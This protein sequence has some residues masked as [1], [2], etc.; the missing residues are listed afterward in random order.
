MFARSTVPHASLTQLIKPQC[1]DLLIHIAKH[2]STDKE[3]PSLNV[4]RTVGILLK[5]VCMSKFCAALRTND[6][7]SQ[8]DSE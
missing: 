6:T 3:S 7:Q 8:Q 5:K 4:K 2:M 1:F